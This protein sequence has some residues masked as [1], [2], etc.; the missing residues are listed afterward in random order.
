MIEKIRILTSC[1]SPGGG[2][3]VVLWK[4]MKKHTGNNAEYYRNDIK[5]QNTSLTSCVSPGGGGHVVLW[6]GMKKHTGINAEY[7]MNDRK[8]SEYLQAV[9]VQEVEDMLYYGKV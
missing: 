5:D 9:L 3:H 8:R 1:V 6:K 7:Y 2:G 4:G